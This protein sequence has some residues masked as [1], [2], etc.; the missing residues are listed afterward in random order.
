MDFFE[1]TTEEI[2]I[3]ELKKCESQKQWTGNIKLDGLFQYWLKIRMQLNYN[4]T[5][6]EVATENIGEY[7]QQIESDTDRQEEMV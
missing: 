1:S 3:S 4:D 5:T 6:N 7:D 2:V